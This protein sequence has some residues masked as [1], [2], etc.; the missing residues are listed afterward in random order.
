MRS[1]ETMEATPS[2]LSPRHVPIDRVA[3][4]ERVR[5]LARF[6]GLEPE[7]IAAG[8]LHAVERD[9]NLRGRAKT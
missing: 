5:E 4:R 9:P 2:N 8:L 1:S 3:Q 7:A 6:L